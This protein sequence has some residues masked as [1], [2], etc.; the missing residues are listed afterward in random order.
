MR[1]VMLAKPV[2][3]LC[4]RARHALAIGAIAGALSACASA[5]LLGSP[6]H[7]VPIPKETVALLDKKRM[8]AKAP[9]FIRI[10][11]EE[12]ELEV[13]KLRDDGRFYLLKTFP[14][15]NWSGKLGPK[16]HA[17]D[18]QSPE[19]FY[20]ITPQQMNPKS[21]Y[22]LAFNLGYPNPYDKSNRRTGDSLMVH[23]GCGSS[24]CYAM[25]D[26]LMEELYALM[27]EA[28]DGGQTVVHVHAFPFHMTKANMAR[29]A[30][31]EWA[32]FWRTLKQAHDYFELT[33]QLPTIAVC[34]RRY[35]VNVKMA[36]GDPAKLNPAGA[37]PAFLHPKPSPFTPKPGDQHAGAEEPVAAPGPKMRSV[38][39]ADQPEASPMG[40]TK[41]SQ[42]IA[43]AIAEW[44]QG[45][46][47]SLG[48]GDKTPK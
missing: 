45:L 21:H 18:F 8:D 12:S 39:G 24:G 41:A 4:Y 43:G 36:S 35:V 15:C 37:C 11:K 31:S 47:T 9:I 30:K 29:H 25:T 1:G 16:V 38:A 7:L 5:D 17:G 6:P 40:L 23:G 26:A 22:H 46:K 33:R 10:Y 42:P 27:R 19:G 48:L 32:G 14:I 2:W 28:F 3:S 44:W 13:W 34:N 20:T